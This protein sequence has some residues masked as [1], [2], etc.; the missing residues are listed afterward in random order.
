MNACVIEY[1]HFNSMHVI[2][3]KMRRK[4][5]KRLS[6]YNS[7]N[8]SLQKARIAITQELKTNT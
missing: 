3:D 7:S 1:L 2:F 5:T 6:K 8:Q 4:Q